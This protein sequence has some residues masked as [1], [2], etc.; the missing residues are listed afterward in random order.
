MR[1]L[2][3]GASGHVGAFLTKAL[4]GRGCEVAVMVR[5]QSD[6]WRIADVLDQVTVIYGA[7]GDL[8]NAREAL[9]AWQPVM[10]F[11][12][13]WE[14]VTGAYRNDPAQITRNVAGSLE[15]FEAMRE[16]GMTTW[17]GLGSQAE[18]GA[19]EGRLSEELPPKPVTAYGV[20]KL[21]LCL[22]TEKLCAMTETRF[23][24]L[25]LLAAYGPMDDPRHLLP[26]VINQLLDGERPALTPGE[27]RWDYLY[28]EDAA[29]AIC[30]LALETSASGVFNLGSGDALTVRSLVETVRDLIDP[31]LPLGL[32]D[33]PYRPDQVM[34]LEG[35]LAKLTTATGWRPEVTMEE[36]LRRTLAWHRDVRAKSVR[37]S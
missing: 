20:S 28:I 16:A 37:A 26:S 1:C 29:E 11:H 7:L 21:C 27:Q 33:V 13:A 30:R 10:V 12:C 3:T 34:H 6:V 2:V 17:V 18:Y 8:G 31:A 25:R 19:V 36:G 9:N 23:L 5:P 32:G 4:L 14:G 15:L 24:W 35:D 22:M